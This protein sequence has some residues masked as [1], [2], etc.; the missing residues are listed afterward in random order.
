MGRERGD[1]CLHRRL[2]GAGGFEA[3]GTSRIYDT[4]TL[5]PS[6]E[7]IQVILTSSGL[8]HTNQSY[9]K[10]VNS[11]RA[12]GPYTGTNFGFVEIDWSAR[13]GPRI[14]LKALDADGTTAFEHVIQLDQLQG[15]E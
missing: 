13:P 12:A 6:G 8:T 4:R 3:A 1:A 11:Y 9:A 10:A 14:A 5:G 2:R 7:R 15:R